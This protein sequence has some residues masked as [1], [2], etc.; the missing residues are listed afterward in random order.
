VAVGPDGMASLPNLTISLLHLAGYTNTAPS[1]P[2][3][4]FPMS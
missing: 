2:S 4:G 1:T 3:T